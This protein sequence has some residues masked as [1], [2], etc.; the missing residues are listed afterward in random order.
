MGF[1]RFCILKT[2]LEKDFDPFRVPQLFQVRD[3]LVQAYLLEGTAIS[4]RCFLTAE[5][6]YLQV[7]LCARCRLQKRVTRYYKVTRFEII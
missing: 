3:R 5:L 6:D 7:N 1:H 2:H 4:I